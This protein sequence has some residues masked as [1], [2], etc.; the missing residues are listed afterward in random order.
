MPKLI[1]M[2]IFSIA[3]GILSFKFELNVSY[4]DYKNYCTV[5]L[6]VS[7][8]V[9]TIMGIWIAFVYPNAIKRLQDPD[10]IK[11]ADFTSTL[12]DTR[13]LESIV[14]SVLESA[15]VA[16][17]I[18]L[19]FFAKLIIGGTALYKG[20]HLVFESTGVAFIVFLSLIQSSA[21]FGVIWSNYLFIDDLH[22][23]RET[24]E[25]HNDF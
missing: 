17:G 19:V 12:Q 15:T 9:F 18:T 23:R 22:T 20:N 25:R 6:A 5:L 21:I 3:I 11:I 16:T 1:A 10:K 8:M 13:R 14:G 4:V 2:A 24:Q 7:G